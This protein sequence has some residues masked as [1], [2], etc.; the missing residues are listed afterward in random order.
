MS[1][2]NGRTPVPQ[3]TRTDQSFIATASQTTFATLGYTPGFELVWLNGVKLVRGDDYTAVNGSDI[4]LASGA[5]A[6]DVLEFIAFKTFEA[7]SFLSGAHLGPRNRIINGNF[8]INQREVSGT[9]VLSAG[10]YGHDMWKA[11]ASG[12][13]YTFAT[14]ENVTTITISA[15]SLKQII[16]GDDLQSGTYVLSWTGTLQM[17]IDG[18][19]AGD[20]GM[21]D[22]LT[23][24]TDA[25]VETSGTGEMSLVQLEPGSVAT[26]FE[27]LAR[28]AE[29]LRCQAYYETGYQVEYSS[30]ETASDLRRYVSFKV[31]KA[32]VPHTVTAAGSRYTGG[33]TSVSATYG[34]ISGP[35]IHG[36]T[37]RINAS[38]T[39][40]MQLTWTAD[41]SP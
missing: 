23:G 35:Y 36:F 5:A 25:E 37:W 14:S 26:S 6:D 1:G 8:A 9:V 18:G 30:S 2:Y 27:L 32:S 41:C 19:T 40:G 10:A 38:D 13:T 31:T 17:K 7:A 22:T 24:G 15:G 29:L 11:G 39:E 21:I 4:V 34:I 3:A 33:G 28:T 16:S 20:S 12:C